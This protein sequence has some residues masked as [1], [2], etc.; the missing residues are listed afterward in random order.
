M[1]LHFLFGLKKIYKQKFRHD[2]KK[3]SK[4]VGLDDGSLLIKSTRPGQKLW[5]NFNY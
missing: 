1:I 4:I 3:G 5:K 2:F